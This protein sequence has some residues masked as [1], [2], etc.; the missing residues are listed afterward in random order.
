M[1]RAHQTNHDLTDQLQQSAAILQ[2]CGFA[3]EARRILSE[4]HTACDIDP[5]LDA[6]L[7]QLVD[8]R[9]EWTLFDDNTGQVLQGIAQRLEAL[10]AQLNAPKPRPPHHAE[11]PQK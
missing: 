10:H 9:R 2:L 4:T 3:C 11:R 5:E 6:R 7:A 1:S 8:A